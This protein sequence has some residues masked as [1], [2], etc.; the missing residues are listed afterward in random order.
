MR[1]PLGR[2]SL[3]AEGIP[4]DADAT[5]VIAATGPAAAGLGSQP[6]AALLADSFDV[7]AEGFLVPR[8]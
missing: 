3:V 7:D 5:L 2:D 6:R 8:G 1:P 4:D